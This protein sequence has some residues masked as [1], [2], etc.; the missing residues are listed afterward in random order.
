MTKIEQ[1]LANASSNKY[2]DDSAAIAK[3]AGLFI[4]ARFEEGYFPFI[5]GTIGDRDEYGLHEGYMIC[6]SYGVD[7][8]FTK[9]FKRIEK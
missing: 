7:H 5:C 1:I 4:S 9:I 3:L 6:P 2:G 8:Q